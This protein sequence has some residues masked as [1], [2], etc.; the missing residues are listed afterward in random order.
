MSYVPRTLLIDIYPVITLKTDRNLGNTIVE[1]FGCFVKDIEVQNIQSNPMLTKEEQ[2]YFDTKLKEC[3]TSTCKD[4]D[5]SKFIQH[6]TELDDIRCKFCKGSNVTYR[7]LQTRS[8]DEGMTTFY[9][10][11]LCGKQ[12]RT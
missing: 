2:H 11:H 7:L 4:S 1:I 9:V 8:A 12:W 3:P 6:L 10:C 5:S